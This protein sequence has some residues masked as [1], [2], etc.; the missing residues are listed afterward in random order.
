MGIF[1]KFRRKN[2]SKLTKEEKKGRGRSGIA[3]DT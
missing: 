3:R 2:K 1:K